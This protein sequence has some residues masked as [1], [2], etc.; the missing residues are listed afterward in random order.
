MNKHLIARVIPIAAALVGLLA[1]ARVST[2][3]MII[4]PVR[5]PAF[6]APVGDK[7]VAV[8]CARPAGAL[9]HTRLNRK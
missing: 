5:C 3:R 4:E 8:P 7:I 9:L 2:A 6:T 1:G